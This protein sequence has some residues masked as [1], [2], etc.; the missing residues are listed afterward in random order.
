MASVQPAV[1]SFIS[2]IQALEREF[3]K[4]VTKLTTR[5]AKM[6]DTQLISSVSQLNFFQELVDKG[7]GNALNSFDKEYE[8]MLAAAISEANKRGIPPLAG[9]SVEGLEVLRDMDYK[10]LLGRAEMYANELQMQLF[11]GVYAGTPPNAIVSNLLTAMSDNKYKLASHQL[12]V[13]AYD[14]LKTFDDM[15]RYKTFQG[16]DVRW[17]YVG[18]QDSATR[19]ECQSTKDREPKK[20]YTESEASSSDTPFGIRGGFNCRHSW[21][22]K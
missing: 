21:M 11:R 16:Q 18:P 12:N 2:N 13:V 6:S 10:R 17:V 19:P 3:E 8:K 14:G 22:V 20:G 9:A 7:Y 5:M 15:A 1:D 4:D